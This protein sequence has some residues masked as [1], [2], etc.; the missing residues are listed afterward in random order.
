MILSRKEYFIG[1]TIKRD[2]TKTNLK[3]YQPDIINNTTQGFKEDLKLLMTFNTPATPHNRIVR[4]QENIQKYQIAYRKDAGVAQDH[5]YTVSSS[6]DL[7]Y[8]TQYVNS[9]NVWINQT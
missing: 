3:I 5:Y 8:L 4:N 2:L 7:N 1:C 9:L 6:H